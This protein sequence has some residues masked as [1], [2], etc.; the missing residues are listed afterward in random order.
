M[1]KDLDKLFEETK[2]S[3]AKAM[4]SLTSTIAAGWIVIAIQIAVIFGMLFLLFVDDTPQVLRIIWMVIVF[5]HFAFLLIGSIVKLVKAI[6]EKH[7]VKTTTQSIEIIHD[8]MSGVDSKE[9]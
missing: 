8:I 5:G 3:G 4:N 2:E 9:V 6:K 1:D 7:F